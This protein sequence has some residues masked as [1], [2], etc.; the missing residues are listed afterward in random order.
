MRTDV[1]FKA[2]F[3]AASMVPLIIPGI[4]YTVSWIFL[5]SPEIGLLNKALEPLFGARPRHLHIW[6]MIWVEG[7]HSVA[8]RLPAHGRGVPVDGPLARGVGA[9]VGRHAACRR[10]RKITLPLVRPAIVA[11]VLS[12]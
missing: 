11:A 2:L 9:D 7:L 5:A 12:S 8:H 3:F 6:G 10:F 1:P 4:L